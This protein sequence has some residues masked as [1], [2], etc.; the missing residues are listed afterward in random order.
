MSWAGLLAHSCALTHEAEISPLAHTNPPTC[1]PASHFFFSST[2]PPHTLPPNSQIPVHPPARPCPRA[3]RF[4]PIRE[5]EISRSMTTRYFAD[6]YKNAEVSCAPISGSHQ[7]QT[8]ITSNLYWS[9][10][11]SVN[12]TP[13]GL[14]L[15][16]LPANHPSHPSCHASLTSHPI[17]WMW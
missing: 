6:L 13:T 9:V 10:F 12:C 14:Y 16:L 2:H 17:R 3:A 15:L 8:A 4:A 7:H 11:V 5:A 1:L